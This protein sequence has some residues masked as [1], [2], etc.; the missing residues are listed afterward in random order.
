MTARVLESGTS[1]ATALYLNIVHFDRAVQSESV[2]KR[3]ED[4]LQEMHGAIFQMQ[5]R[6]DELERENKR[7]N[8]EIKALS[9]VSGGSPPIALGLDHAARTGTDDQ[10]T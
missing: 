1:Y 3:C 7:L 2:V 4:N 5:T 9:E 6:L 8:K 10:G